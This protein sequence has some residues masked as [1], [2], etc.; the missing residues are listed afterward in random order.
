[1]L[2]DVEG[3]VIGAAKAPD[4]KRKQQPGFHGPHIVK[5]EGR[6]RKACENKQCGFENDPFGI[7]QIFHS[8][9]DSRQGV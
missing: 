4:D 1:M 9:F 7:G 6:G 3:E 8:V 2:D 5:Q